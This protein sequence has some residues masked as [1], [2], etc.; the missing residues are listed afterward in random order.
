MFGITGHLILTRRAGSDRPTPIEICPGQPWRTVCLHASMAHRERH[1]F[2][3]ANPF[4]DR[5]FRVRTQVAVTYGM[6]LGDNAAAWVGAWLALADRPALL[7]FAFLAYLFGLWQCVRRRS[8]RRYR[9][10]RPQAH[11]TRQ[12]T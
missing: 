11:A 6:L 10:R 8:Y 4:D 3:L 2:T 12:G 7:G 1:S 5:P 9:Q